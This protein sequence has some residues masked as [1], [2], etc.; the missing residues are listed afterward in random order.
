MSFSCSKI[1]SSKHDVLKKKKKNQRKT[2]IKLDKVRSETVNRTDGM[3]GKARPDW[4]ENCL[5]S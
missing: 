1:G 3:I 5:R 2:S 4:R